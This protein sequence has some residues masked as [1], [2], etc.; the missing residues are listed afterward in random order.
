VGVGGVLGDDHVAQH[1]GAAVLQHCAHP[2]EEAELGLALE[3][4]DDEGGHDEVERPGGQLVLQAADAQGGAVRVEPLAGGG[5]HRLAG[6]DAG[7]R[8]AGVRGEHALGCL[9]GAHTQLEDAA[10]AGAT[11]HD[12]PVLQQV[13]L[14]DLVADHL[15]VAL[16]L[17]DVGGVRQRTATSGSA[18]RP[19]WPAPCGRCRPCA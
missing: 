10:R 8:R 1:E 4:V 9:A 12:E 7:E 17:E 19:C 14:A 3:V 13:V 18:R 15:R 5:E 16:G 6:V 2:A 11:G